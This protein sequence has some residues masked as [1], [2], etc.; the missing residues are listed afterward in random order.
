MLGLKSIHIRKGE[1]KPNN[2]L[3]WMNCYYSVSKNAE[4]LHKFL[5]T[6]FR[7]P[8]DGSVT[9]PFSPKLK[10]SPSLLVPSPTVQAHTVICLLLLWCTM[11]YG[12]AATGRSF[13]TMDIPLNM[14]K[15]L[16]LVLLWVYNQFLVVY[17]IIQPE[18]GRSLNSYWLTH[19]GWDKMTDILQTT[20]SNAFFFN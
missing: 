18:T 10:W 20:F 8:S 11:R 5:L 2:L 12:R 7:L 19:L 15:D 1:L 9:N 16:C 6:T 14:H 13:V 3:Q 17:A 4:L